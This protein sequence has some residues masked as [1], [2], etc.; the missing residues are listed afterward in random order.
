MRAV[1]QNGESL[2]GEMRMATTLDRAVEVAD[3]VKALGGLSLTQSD[4]AKATGASERS[5]RNWKKN[6]AIRSAYEE[7]LRDVRDVAL[8]LQDSLTPR[9]V[10]QW[11]RARNRLLAGARPLELIS[12][13]EV[14][15]VKQAAQAFVDGA[16]V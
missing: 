5:V 4:L 15:R 7:R 9:G 8:I 16:Y 6:S 3:V 13:G 2:G 1:T 10:A 14:E 11:L 12:Q